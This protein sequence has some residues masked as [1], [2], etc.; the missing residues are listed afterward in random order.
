MTAA[1]LVHYGVRTRSTPHRYTA[2]CADVLSASAEDSRGPAWSGIEG[3]L[4]PVMSSG[5]ARPRLVRGV[6]TVVL[7]RHGESIWNVEK[8]FTGWCDVPL[9]SHGHADARD[10]GRLLGE[11]GM[12]FDMAFT[13]K[14]ERAWKTC[15]AA[16]AFS[17]QSRVPIIHS[18]RLNERHYGILQGH[19]KDCPH[20][21]QAFGEDR[22]LQW[23]KSFSDAPPT[24]KDVDA[25]TG[26]ARE[27]YLESLKT[28]DDRYKYSTA[29]GSWNKPDSPLQHVR[30]DDVNLH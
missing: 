15:E 5:R 28:V 2:V 9:T 21:A 4:G 17:G 12:K 16:L 30:L 29:V 1:K 7:L 18:S 11:R 27:Q 24:Q 10:A 8:R 22:L 6:H 13:S 3:F 19:H 25:L 23:R 14:L 26:N 20:L